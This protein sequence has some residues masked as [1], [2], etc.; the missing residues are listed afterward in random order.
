MIGQ[1][2]ANLWLLLLTML[3]CSVLYPLVLWGV[4]RTVFPDKAQ[5]SLLDKNGGPAA[6][7]KDAAGSRLIA[8]PFTRDEYFWPR[9]SAASYNAAASAASNWAASNYLLRDRVARTLGPLAKYQGGPKKGQRAGPDVEAWFQKDRFGG[10]PGIVGQW[11][12]A[13]PTLA[14]NW[15]KADP[16]HAAYVTA[17]QNAHPAEV[18]RW[19][20]D[21][22]DQPAPRPED[23]AVRF[24]KSFSA[25]YP[26]AFPD[27]VEAKAPDGRAAKRLEPVK[28]GTT[29]QGIFFDLWRQEHPDADL[30]PVPADMVLAS[31]SGLDPHITLANARYQLDRVASAWAARTKVPREQV[32]QAIRELLQEKKETPLGGLAGVDLVNVLEVNLALTDRMQQLA[33]SR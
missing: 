4:G 31:G 3:L 8:Q 13:H 24:F 21:H 17:W 6:R 5:G 9:P 28:A 11:A 20:K 30:E 16:L 10:Q 2:R 23:L 27:A 33:P 32:A 18:D 1:L 25:T 14:Q 12:D 26:G 29:I 15:V 7:E 19:R 22:P